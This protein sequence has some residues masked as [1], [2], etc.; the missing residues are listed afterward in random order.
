MATSAEYSLFYRALLQKRPIIL[1]SLQIHNTYFSDISH[2]HVT[3]LLHMWH[4]KSTHTHT[5]THAHPHT[6]PHPHTTRSRNMGFHECCF[7]C[8][9]THSHVTPQNH[10][11]TPIPTHTYTHTYTHTHTHRFT[12]TRLTVNTRACLSLLFYMCHHSF[13]T[14][15]SCMNVLWWC[16]VWISRDTRYEWLCVT[17]DSYVTWDIHIWR[18][19]FTHGITHPLTHPNVHLHLHP[20]PHPQTT[21]RW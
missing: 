9:I 18:N 6:C 5:H 19:S 3:W 10:T 11:L 17:T 20:H 12:H 8:D 7:T 4:H 21:Y 16:H 13:I 14:W 2:S 1:R 15:M